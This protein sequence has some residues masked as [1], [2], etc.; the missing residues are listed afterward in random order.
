MS[1]PVLEL[2]N[3]K[4]VLG[5]ELILDRVNISVNAGES[6]VLIGPSGGGKS[7]LLKT[8]A[9]V[10]ETAEGDVFC[11]GKKW[12]DL[13]VMGKHDL[14]AKVGMQFQKGALFDHLTA[15]ENIAFPLREHLQWSEEKVSQR[16]MECLRR[17]DLEKA[18]QLL[19]FEMSGGMRQRLSVARAIALEPEL[20][21]FDDPTAGLDPLNSDSMA[22]LIIDLKKK[23]NATLII[24]T[25]DL[26]RAYQ[27]AGRIFLVAQTE[28]IEIGSKDD[29]EKSKDP[30]VRQFLDGRLEGPLKI[31]S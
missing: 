5:G 24:V 29:A 25:H 14:Y 2:K 6:I 7:V 3:V 17:V 19:P 20:L 12:S 1:Q 23:I 13:S 4:V 15:F 31:L 16:V 9:G 28:V 11:H 18:A 10:Y 8:M 30:R 22:D 27:L 26:Y 21:F